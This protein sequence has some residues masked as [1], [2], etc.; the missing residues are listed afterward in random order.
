VREV[1]GPIPEHLQKWWTQDFW[2]CHS[3][4]WWRRHWERTSI[5]T[6][7]L[8]DTMADGWQCWR[9]WHK[10]VAPDN[11]TEIEAVEA[12]GGR[13][14][15]YIRLVGRRQSQVKLEEYCWP[16][17]LRSLPPQY[18]KTPFLRIQE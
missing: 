5:V 4:A 1:D 6:V 3:A 15:G 10:A 11:T 13:Y 8:A 18:T 12:D 17:S 14:L 9:D 2:A 7:E 16:D